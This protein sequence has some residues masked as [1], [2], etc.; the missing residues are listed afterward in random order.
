MENHNVAKYVYDLLT[1]KSLEYKKELYFKECKKSQLV[2]LWRILF[3]TDMRDSE[4]LK[5]RV[6][7]FGSNLKTQDY[8]G[9]DV[10]LCLVALLNLVIK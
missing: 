2:L 6:Y 8:L 7:E 1:D 4:L 9:R 10:F 3:E 5:E